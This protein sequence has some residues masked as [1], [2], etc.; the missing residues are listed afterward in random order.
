MT[1]LTYIGCNYYNHNNLYNYVIVTYHY[2]I[3][4]FISFRGEVSEIGYMLSFFAFFFCKIY[5]VEK[6]YKQ[7]LSLMRMYL[8]I[9]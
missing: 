7:I 9:L 8:F 5:S 6:F 3:Y 4:H 1:N 2:V